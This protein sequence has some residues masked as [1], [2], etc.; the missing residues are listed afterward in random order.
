MLVRVREAGIIRT[1]L[2]LDT[3]IPRRVDEQVGAELAART[4]IACSAESAAET[5]PARDRR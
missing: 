1:A 5:R 4:A 3:G 2:R